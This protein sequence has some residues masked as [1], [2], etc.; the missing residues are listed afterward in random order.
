ML[1]FECV[2][3]CVRARVPEYVC[4]VFEHLCLKLSEVATQCMLS[5]LAVNFGRMIHVC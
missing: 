3:L 1:L 4:V 2:C 5:K